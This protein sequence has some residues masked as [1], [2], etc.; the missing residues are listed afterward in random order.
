MTELN[1]T[2]LTLKCILKILT[3][4]PN[5]VNSRRDR[6]IKIEIEMEME[7]ERQ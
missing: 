5:V 3:E 2:E 1:R 7:N 4:I 6:E